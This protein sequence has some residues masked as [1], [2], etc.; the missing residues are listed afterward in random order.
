[1]PLEI[2]SAVSVLPSSDAPGGGEDSLDSLQQVEVIPLTQE[3]KL[4][5][6]WGVRIR[7][8]SHLLVHT[9]NLHVLSAYSVQELNRDFP[10]NTRSNVEFLSFP[11]MESS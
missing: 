7:R 6:L 2:A 10:C 9:H 1:M 8:H 5:C 3:T 11:L 4:T